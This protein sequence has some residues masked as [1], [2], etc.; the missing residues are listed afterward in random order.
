VLIICFKLICFMRIGLEYLIMSPCSFNQVLELREIRNIHA[1]RGYP[2]FAFLHFFTITNNKLEV[3][4][5]SEVEASLLP[6]CGEG[7][8]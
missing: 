4:L 7:G 6:L 5:M 8:S 3:M 1:T 2:I